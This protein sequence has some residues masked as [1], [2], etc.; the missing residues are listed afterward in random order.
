MEKTQIAIR[1]DSVREANNELRKQIEEFTSLPDIN[2]GGKKRSSED[3]CHTE[4]PRK[5][6]EDQDQ[7]ENDVM[8]IPRMRRRLAQTEN[9]LKRTRTKLL[10]S[11]STLKVKREADGPM[12]ISH[13]CVYH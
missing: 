5:R 10:G 6:L 7:E 3:E 1:L 8:E 13:Y 12:L 4:S 9:E 2:C 11:H